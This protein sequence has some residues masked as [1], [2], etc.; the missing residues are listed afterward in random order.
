MSASLRVLPLFRQSGADAAQ[1]VSESSLSSNGTA[2]WSAR[3]G[4]GKV[5]QT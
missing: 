2:L 1:E 5:Y 3:E 4:A